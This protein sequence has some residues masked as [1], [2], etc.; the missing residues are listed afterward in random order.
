VAE[1]P[2]QAGEKINKKTATKK[3]HR[4]KAAQS[5]GPAIQ[6]AAR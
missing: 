5:K 3:S 6:S 4:E 1:P 2:A